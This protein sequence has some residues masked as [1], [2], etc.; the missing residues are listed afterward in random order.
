MFLSADFV[1]V[2]CCHFTTCTPSLCH[3]VGP[4]AAGTDLEDDGAIR[5]I[6]E[7]VWIGK[8]RRHGPRPSAC[9]TAER[10]DDI[11]FDAV[12]YFWIGGGFPERIGRAPGRSGRF[13]AGNGR[14]AY[15]ENGASTESES[16]SLVWTA[17]DF[18]NGHGA[19]DRSWRRGPGPEDESGG[20]G[21][22]IGAQRGDHRVVA[23]A[24]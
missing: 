22:G 13:R 5:A 21:A 9:F 8:E 14:R 24:D 20:N 19:R 11:L 3:C 18:G 4:G 10:G 1:F 2:P 16:V 15:S 17:R 6:G 7:S 12:S 23:T